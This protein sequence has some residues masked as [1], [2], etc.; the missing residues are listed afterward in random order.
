MG[1]VGRVMF[2]TLVGVPKYPCA[3]RVEYLVYLVFECYFS[4]SSALF[5]FYL[6]YNLHYYLIMRSYNEGKSSGQ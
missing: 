4:L 2:M 1:M 5:L 6:D 3:C